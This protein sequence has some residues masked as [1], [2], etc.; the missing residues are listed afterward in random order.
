MTTRQARLIGSYWPAGLVFGLLM[1]LD[2]FATAMSIV[3][4]VALTSPVW[5]AMLFAL[6][7]F[8]R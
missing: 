2:W 4:L 3:I 5:L 7:R 8:V 1:Q 6:L